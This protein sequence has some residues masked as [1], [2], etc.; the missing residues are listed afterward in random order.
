[1]AER[2][3]MTSLVKATKVLDRLVAQGMREEGIA[4]ASL[5]KTLGQPTNSVHNILRTLCAVGYAR[6][7]RRGVYA[8]GPKL[9]QLAPAPEVDEAALRPRLL[10]VLTACAAAYEEA[11][12]CSRLQEG[13]RCI[14]VQVESSQAV[15]VNQPVIDQ[16]PFYSKVSCRLLLAHCAEREREQVFARQGMP[17]AAWPEAATPARLAAELARIRNAGHLV[18]YE[19]EREVVAI[20]CPLFTHCGSFWGSLGSYAPTYRM[21]GRREAEWLDHLRRVTRETVIA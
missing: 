1:M 12:N 21:Q 13:E 6:Q 14:F 10:E 18:M 3:L 2:P 11:Y 8:A 7:V 19:Q 20:A 5:A 15:G 16:S 17:G 9:L 4:L